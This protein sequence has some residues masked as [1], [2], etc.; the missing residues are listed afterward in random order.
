MSDE[1]I[2][3]RESP[4]YSGTWWLEKNH[5][6][7]YSSGQIFDSGQCELIHKQI[8]S[9]TEF[10]AAVGN[11]NIAVKADKEILS[12]EEQDS[13]NLSIRKNTVKWLN[14]H[15]PSLSWIFEKLTNVVNDVN[16]KFFKFDLAYIE[17]LQYTIYYDDSNFY[18]THIDMMFGDIVSHRKLSFSVQL[19]DENSYEGGNL[20]IIVGN[21]PIVAARNQGFVTFFPSY[22]PHK[23]T[24]VTKGCRRS[25]V[26]WVCG[27]RF[28]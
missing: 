13:L 5:V 17:S 9:Y 26:G 12:P 21:E 3:K 20:E 27:P 6:D 15:D 25:L 8:E 10:K 1:T 4:L 18:D 2:E 23:V 16:S 28:K 22:F 11:S 24:P 7:S 14:S 19:D